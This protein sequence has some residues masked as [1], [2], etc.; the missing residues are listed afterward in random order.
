MNKSETIYFEGLPLQPKPIPSINIG[1]V[2]FK[3]LLKQTRP[4]LPPLGES[5]EAYL[6]DQSAATQYANY[7]YETMG[8]DQRQARTAELIEALSEI[9]N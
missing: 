8:A 6:E 5:P 3:R 7:I 4:V 9:E 1:E 2:V